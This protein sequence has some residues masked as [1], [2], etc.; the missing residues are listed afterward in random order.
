MKVSRVFLAGVVAVVVGSPAR[1]GTMVYNTLSSFNA[2][3]TSTTLQDFQSVPYTTLTS[4]P[5]NLGSG[6]SVQMYGSLTTAYINGGSL[7]FSATNTPGG[8]QFSF[9]PGVTAFGMDVRDLGTVGSTT[10][11]YGLTNGETGNFVV[12][13]TGSSN[14]SLFTGLTSTTAFNWIKVSNSRSG[15]VVYF[16]NIRYGTAAAA[17]PEPSSVV[18]MGV[19]LGAAGLVAARRRRAA[20]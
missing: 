15:D 11:S 19:A 7:S 9:T 4:S 12:N 1:A 18:L 2:A 6:L 5:T 8:V 10:L 3:V 20:A 14:N 17:V 13:F 16:D